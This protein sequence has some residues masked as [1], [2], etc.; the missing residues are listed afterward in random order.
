MTLW[1]ET[2]GARNPSFRRYRCNE[3][4]DDEGIIERRCAVCGEWMVLDLFC[5]SNTCRRGF[6]CECRACRQKRRRGYTRRTTG[7]ETR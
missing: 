7:G 6:T 2:P 1:H 4:T 3:R 5:R